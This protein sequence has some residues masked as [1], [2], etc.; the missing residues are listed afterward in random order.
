MSYLE[1]AADL[2]GSDIGKRVI[3]QSDTGGV[4]DRVMGHLVAVRHWKED[5]GT[6][7]TRARLSVFDGTVVVTVPGRT[8]AYLAAD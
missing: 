1:K 5:D 7:W 6:L 8:P 4:M 2:G 3:F